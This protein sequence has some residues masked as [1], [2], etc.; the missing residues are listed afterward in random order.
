[1]SLTINIDQF[2][3]KFSKLATPASVDTLLRD[4]S[5]NML[6]ETKARIH[7]QGKNASGSQIGTYSPT[8]IKT[9]VKKNRGTSSKVILSLSGQME[10]DYKVI[11]VQ[12]GYGLGFSNSLN[13]D[14]AQGLQYGNRNL[15]GYGL[16][17]GLTP[18]ET[19]DMILII[20]DWLTK[21]N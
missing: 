13:A 19:K 9:R 11:P 6:R 18:D 16:I 10:N 8:Y 3:S 15:K 2:I 17:Y 14:K 21:L 12:G 20:E 1:M 5:T 4:I 7:E